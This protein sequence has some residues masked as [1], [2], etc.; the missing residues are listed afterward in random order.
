MK[1]KI[2]AK[3]FTTI[4]SLKYELLTIRR[5]LDDEIIMKTRMSIYDRMDDCIEA[6]GCLINY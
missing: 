5:E 3:S 6:K 1:R 4:N 2:A